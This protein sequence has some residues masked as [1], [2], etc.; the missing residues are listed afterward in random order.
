MCGG[1]AALLKP[2]GFAVAG[3]LMLAVS[4]QS[5]R[6]RRSAMTIAAVIAGAMIPI[7]VAGASLFATGQL[8]QVPMLWK[9]ISRYAAESAW[10][11]GDLYKLIVVGALLFFPI[12]VRLWVCRRDREPQRTPRI[13]TTFAV[14]W[15]VLELA[16]VVMQKRMY[17]YHFLVLVAPAALLY[18]LIPRAARATSLA[19]GLGPVLALSVLGAWRVM[20][21]NYHGQQRHAISQYLLARAYPTDAV[22]REDGARILLETNLRAGSRYPLTFLFTNYDQAPLEYGQAI[23]TDFHRTKPQYII[24]FTN[25]ESWIHHQCDYYT[26]LRRRPIRREN[27]L[28]AWRDI[29]AYVDENYVEETKLGEETIFRRK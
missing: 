15:L 2:T 29:R 26:E 14:A 22:W 23:L 8:A 4:L 20:D 16:G 25:F 10:E 18:G 11:L 24:L 6:S 9:Q 19:A 12:V 3:A 28:K 21:W 13:L 5:G 27:Y 7:G 1:C 17:A